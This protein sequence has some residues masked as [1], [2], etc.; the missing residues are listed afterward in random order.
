MAYVKTKWKKGDNITSERL[1]NIED[2]IEEALKAVSEIN[3]AELA[4]EPVEVAP[5]EGNAN[6]A[7]L[8]AKVNELIE[9]LKARGILA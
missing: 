8:T 9:A 5:I 6:V 4:G 1:N 3:T 7:V 2:G